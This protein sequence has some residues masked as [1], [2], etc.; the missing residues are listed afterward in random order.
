MWASFLFFFFLFWENPASQTW[1][2]PTPTYV[3]TFA[4]FTSRSF[5]RYFQWKP[6]KN[7]LLLLA[8]ERQKTAILKYI[9]S[10][11][12]FIKKTTPQEKIFNQSFNWPERRAINQLHPPLAFLF[13]KRGGGKRLKD[14]SEGHNP[15]TLGHEEKKQNKTVSHKIL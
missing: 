8:W 14:V 12:F 6:E 2:T 10:I 11:L 3:H 5:T 7:Y 13:H 15:G 4:S 9:E 1:E